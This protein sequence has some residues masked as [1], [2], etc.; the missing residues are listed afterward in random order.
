MCR[1][2]SYVCRSCRGKTGSGTGLFA[3]S[4]PPISWI[5]LITRKHGSKYVVLIISSFNQYNF[6]ITLALNFRYTLTLSV[7]I[8]LSNFLYYPQHYWKTNSRKITS[9]I[10]DIMDKVFK[11]K[12]MPQRKETSYWDRINLKEKFCIYIYIYIS[13]L[14]IFLLSYCYNSFSFQKILKY[15]KLKWRNHWTSRNH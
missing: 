4:P 14:L 7:S 3:S 8:D 5:K 10:H 13:V 1:D 6:S 9:K 11:L 12:M 15:K 2:N